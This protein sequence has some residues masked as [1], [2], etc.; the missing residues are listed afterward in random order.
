MSE[1]AGVAEAHRQDGDLGRVVESGFVETEPVAQPIA[2]R[3][4]EGDAAGVGDAAGGLAGDDEAG[5]GR[6]LED[7]AGAEGKLAEGAGAG[8]GEKVM[9]RPGL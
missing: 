1:A 2:A 6:G 8:V 7:W 9:E 3:V 5:V 4:L